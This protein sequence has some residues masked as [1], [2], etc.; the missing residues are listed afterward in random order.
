VASHPQ[1]TTH[2]DDRVGNTLVTSYKQVF[3][4]PDIFICVIGNLLVKNVVLEAPS[5]GSYAK[6]SNCKTKI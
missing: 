6:F 3:N 4:R 2:A 5:L 1:K